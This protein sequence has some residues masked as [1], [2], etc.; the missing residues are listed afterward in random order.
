MSDELSFT[1]EPDA[2]RAAARNL[3]DQVRANLERCRA[4][5][6]EHNADREYPDRLPFP[7]ELLA[8]RTALKR[9]H[10]DLNGYLRYQ[11]FAHR[12]FDADGPG[13]Y[14]ASETMRYPKFRAVIGYPEGCCYELDLI[15]DGLAEAVWYA[16]RHVGHGCERAGQ[17]VLAVY[18]LGEW[19][20][21]IPPVDVLGG[22]DDARWPVMTMADVEAS[23]GT[24]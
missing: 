19:V 6:A 22:P 3:R 1:S 7:P 20:D 8:A 2:L 23:E 4:W 15:A 11:G 5:Y 17:H 18:P 13:D 24:N 10:N 16:S 9:R 21:A 12:T 14:R